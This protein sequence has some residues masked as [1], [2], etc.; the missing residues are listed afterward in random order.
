MTDLTTDPTTLIADVLT[1]SYGLTPQRLDQLPIGQ[2]TINYR[3][4]CADGDVFVKNYLPGTDLTGEADA[5]ELSALGGQHG[6]PVA[7]LLRNNAGHLIDASTPYPISV[8]EWMP[9]KVVTTALT[10]G[11]A[12]GAGNA[13]G[14]IHTTFAALPASAAPSTQARSWLAVDVAELAATI[15]RLTDIA[16]ARLATGPVDSFDAVAVRTLAERRQVLD[17]IPRLLADLPTLTTQVL[18]GDY[19]P[20][21]LLFDDDRLRA[22]I[23][24]RPPDPFFLAYELGRVAF[25]PN[26]VATTTDW[27][28]T[29]RTLIESYLEANPRAA[30]DDIRA[31]ARVALL[32]LLTSLYGVKQH[33]LKPG[34]FQDALDEFWLHRHR[35][36]RILLDHQAATDALLHEL[37]AR[38]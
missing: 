30:A 7:E 6:V 2:G 37:T 35:A 34:L 33:Y 10:A 31:C 36:A 5:I 24:F 38:R 13:L 1:R 8:W 25:Y 28:A 20:V 4:T 18:H 17:E 15:D 11:Q 21:N 22:V 16:E 32:Q 23:D 19:S 29:A 14:L 26:T 3:A 12:R 27:L 9:G